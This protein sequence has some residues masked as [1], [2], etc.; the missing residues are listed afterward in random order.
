MKRAIGGKQGLDANR[1]S[2]EVGGEETARLEECPCGTAEMKDETRY[3]FSSAVRTDGK[4]CS[5][6]S[7]LEQRE[8]SH[9]ARTMVAEKV[10]T[11]GI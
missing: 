9:A 7:R 11:F 4:F 3:F 1:T 8:I 6:S 2:A 10:Q 5:R